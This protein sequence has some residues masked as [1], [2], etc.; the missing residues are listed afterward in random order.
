[1]DKNLI[2]DFSKLSGKTIDRAVQCGYNEN[3]ILVFTDNTY[4]NV[5][6]YYC[7][8]NEH[9]ITLKDSIS[10]IDKKIAGIITEEEYEQHLKNE[11]YRQEI[12]KQDSEFA[13]Y[14]RLK[15]KFGDK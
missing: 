6:V 2:T 3:A 8:D 7:G 1:M 12:A 15:E 9:E 14:Q 5:C 11:K 10:E 4:A 13:E